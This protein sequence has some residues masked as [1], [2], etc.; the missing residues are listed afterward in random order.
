GGVTVTYWLMKPAQRVTIDILDSARRVIRSYVPD[1]TRR[2][3]T[4][5]VAAAGDESGGG[6]GFGVRGPFTSTQGGVNRLVWDLRYAPA[7]SF[8]G[9]ILWGA[10]VLGPQAPPGRYTV[11][12]TVDGRE[13]TRPVVVKRN[14]M[15]TDVTDADLRAQFALAIRI[16]DKVSEAN[17]AV[18]QSRTVKR[19]A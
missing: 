19:E 8:P 18:I 4:R 16:R 10:S 11:R 2:D 9:M 3:T 17:N 7:T 14:P 1:T 5:A 6:G 15:F 12:L 13:Q